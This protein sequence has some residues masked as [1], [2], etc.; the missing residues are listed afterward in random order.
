MLM[1]NRPLHSFD[2]AVGPC[3]SRFRARHADAT[4][5]TPG[6]EA[7]FEFMAP[8]GQHAAPRQPAA[9]YA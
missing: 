9:R 6:D 5:L 2:E 8:I 4:V 1:Q 3:V 7:A